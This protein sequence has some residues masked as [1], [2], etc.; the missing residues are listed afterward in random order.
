[1]SRK[2]LK[3]NKKERIVAGV[4]GG[5]A[6]YYKMDISQIRIAFV[7]GFIFFGVGLLVYLVLWLI[8]P[9]S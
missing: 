6:D 5:L 2:K 9:Q 4:C 8:M 3:R 7:M 1:M